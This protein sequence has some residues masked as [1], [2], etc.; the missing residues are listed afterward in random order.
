V[1]FVCPLSDAARKWYDYKVS[2][3]V[4]CSV[5][6][7]WQVVLRAR[8]GPGG[9]VSTNVLNASENFTSNKWWKITLRL[10]GETV[11]ATVEGGEEFEFKKDTNKLPGTFAFGVKL[12]AVVKFKNVK[13][14]LTKSK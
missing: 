5:A 4:W 11:Y 13:F 2:F 12:G 14:E 9:L 3:E 1:G 8:K 7:G 6:G 10:S